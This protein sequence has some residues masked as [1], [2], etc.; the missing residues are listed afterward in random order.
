MSEA[1]PT[2]TTSTK[3]THNTYAVTLGPD[4]Q[5]YSRYVGPA[6]KKET[7]LSIWIPEDVEV[8]DDTRL[9]VRARKRPTGE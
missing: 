7:G 1:A 5:E 6:W 8:T 2:P 3:P 4:G 9:A